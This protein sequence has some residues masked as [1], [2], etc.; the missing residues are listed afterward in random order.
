MDFIHE[1]M[2]HGE[3]GFSIGAYS[4]RVYGAGYRYHEE[5]ELLYIAEGTLNICI[6]GVNY[7]AE[8]PS[9]FFIDK[10]IPHYVDV[11]AAREKGNFHWYA[12]LFSGSVLGEKGDRC[13]SFPEEKS[14]NTVLPPDE[15]YL[16]LIPKLQEK[17]WGHE[18]GYEFDCKAMLMRIIG[19]IIKTRCYE[20]R[21]KK[22][23]PDS[24]SAVNRIV[25]YIDNHYNESFKILDLAEMNGYSPNYLSNIF[26]RYTGESIAQ[27]TIGRR[28]DAACYL[29][30][31]TDKTISEIATS[32]GFDNISYFNRAFLKRMGTTPGKYRLNAKNKHKKEQII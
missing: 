32:C 1:S 30:A 6:E 14:I 28:I 21:P 7:E 20:D 10:N 31:E 29:L 2:P 9:V 15:I 11:S 4:E 5:Y 13:R 17:A 18:L 26:K 25:D 19:H 8:A 3:P 23:Y 12:I 24:F 22:A 27:Y 16:E